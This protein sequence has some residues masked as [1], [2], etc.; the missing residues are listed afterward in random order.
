MCDSWYQ[1]E[2]CSATIIDQNQ[3]SI[4]SIIDPRLLGRF[5]LGR[6][7][8]CACPGTVICESYVFVPRLETTHRE[9][10]E[11]R[12]G[13]SVQPENNLHLAGVHFMVWLSLEKQQ[14]C[15]T[16]ANKCKD[17]KSHLEQS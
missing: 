11:V 5:E 14:T 1:V 4:S 9:Q 17:V 12:A 3:V 10:V 16:A 8:V 15:E 7:I 6:L 13:T 2:I